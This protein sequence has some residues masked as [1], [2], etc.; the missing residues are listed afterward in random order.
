M[1]SVNMKLKKYDVFLRKNAEELEKN[2]SI[3]H[4]K[5]NS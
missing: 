1:D 2:T 5:E 4:S 3:L